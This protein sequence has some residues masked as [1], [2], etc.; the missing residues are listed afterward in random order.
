MYLLLYQVLYILRSIPVELYQMVLCLISF[1]SSWLSMTFGPSALPIIRSGAVQ[2]S[3]DS[4][5]GSLSPQLSTFQRGIFMMV[6]FK[7]FLPLCLELF[8]QSFS[9]SMESIRG[10]ISL[11]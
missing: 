5:F 3:W 1:D 4:C 11:L 10:V 9:T 6:M 8:G 7:S 2:C